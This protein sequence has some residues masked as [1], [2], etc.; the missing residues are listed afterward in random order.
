MP[1]PKSTF[2]ILFFFLLS[3]SASLPVRSAT[4]SADVAALRAF[5]SAVKPASIPPASCLATWNFSTDPCAVPRITHFTCGVTCSGDRVVQLTLDSQGYTGT[6][7]PFI[8]KLTQLITLDLGDNSFYGPIPSSISS[9][10]NLRNLIL[11]VNSFSGPLPPSIAA[12]ASLETLDLSRNSLSGTL[13]NL[14]SLTGLTRL[15]LSYNK[16]TGPLPRLP[17]NLNELALKANSLSG[18]LT[19]SSFGGLTRLMVVELSEN[20]FTGSLESWFFLLPSLQQ[21]NLA[22]N[23]LT[24]VAVAKPPANSNTGELVAVDLSYNKISGFLPT[25]FGEYPMLRS[26]ALSY[27]DFADQS[28]QYSK[29]DHHCETV[30]GRNYLNRSPPAGFFSGEGPVTGSLGDNCLESCP[31]SSELCLKPQK[32]ASIC[33]Q[34]YG[35]KPKS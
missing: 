18:P 2:S 33:Q 14:N 9:L 34:A 19:K 24:G 7:T 15:D 13:P 16:L 17:P 3:L 4:F 12:L 5:K 29:K 10:P 25:N 6:L 20:S 35:G 30:S 31:S 28:V 22:K 23:S 1:V 27:N 11:R 8:S 26:L 21:V 32:P